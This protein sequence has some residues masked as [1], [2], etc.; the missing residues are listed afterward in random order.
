VR[1]FA[2]LVGWLVSSLPSLQLWLFLLVPSAR[3]AR[4]RP[5]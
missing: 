2:R 1:R 3:R 4:R 5:A